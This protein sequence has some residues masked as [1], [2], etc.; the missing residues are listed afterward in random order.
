M[1]T[2][3]NFYN[4]ALKHKGK[5][6]ILNDNEDNTIEGIFKEI[7][8]KDNSKDK[9]YF[10]AATD[11]KQG[12]IL[13]CNNVKYLVI[14]KNENINDV[15][16]LYTIEKCNYDVN[17]IFNNMIF[18]EPT[19]IK[20]KTTELAYEEIILP[21]NEIL[22]IL[23]ENNF[24]KQI[25]TDDIFIKFKHRWKVIGI[26]YTKDGILTIYA[27]QDATSAE[28]DLINEIPAGAG[29]Y[30]IEIET[31]PN[32]VNI[33][34]G[35]FSKRINVIVKENDVIVENP[36]IDYIS[37][38]RNIAVVSDG[39]IAGMNS[40]TTNITVKYIGK[41]GNTYSEDIIVNVIKNDATKIILSS[42]MDEFT[43]FGPIH[44]TIIAKLIKS[45]VEDTSARFAFDIVERMERNENIPISI[46][47]RTDTTV[48][49]KGNYPNY[50]RGTLIVWLTTD[51]NVYIKQEIKYINA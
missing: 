10:I 38:N 45:G 47:A 43:V 13:N 37:Q 16:N 19:I 3:L 36:K 41:D 14:T 1:N 22:I 5:T 46:A 17:F 39:V 26:D 32:P 7:D 15:Y 29:K 20:N 31:T 28:D 18:P 9:K 48:T 40:G 25:K 51:N 21:A 24:T 4:L 2:L 49:L 42:G 50:G 23:S 8:D 12:D 11:L 35:E 34:G 33:T 6:C 44:T 27:N 30:K